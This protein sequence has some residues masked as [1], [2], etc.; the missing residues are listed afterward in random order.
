MRGDDPNYGYCQGCRCRGEVRAVSLY[1]SIGIIVLRLH[2]AFHG[3]LCKDCISKY[4][5][6]YSL[7]TFFCGWWG[8]ISFILT[9]FLLMINLYH[10][11]SS[12]GM[13]SIEPG[14][15]DD[16]DDDY[17]DEDDDYDDDGDYLGRR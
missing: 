9:P 5:W 2:K 12:F 8:I 14:G 4:F 7:I 15:D 17:D 1:Q 3:R 11:V 13:G 6:E 10:Y 16:E